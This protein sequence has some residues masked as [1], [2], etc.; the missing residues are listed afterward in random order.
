MTGVPIL[1]GVLCLVLVAA[2]ATPDPV[3]ERRPARLPRAE[4]TMPSA[5]GEPDPGDRVVA[6]VGEQKIRESDIGEFVIRYL[7]DRANEA[8]TH[9]IDATILE[10]EAREKGIAVPPDLL[11]AEV[12]RQLAERERAVTAQ[13]GADVTLEVYLRD[14]YG[15]TPVEHREDLSALVRT[16]MLRDR[17]IRFSRM[18]KERV[19]VRDAVFADGEV[20]ARAA[21][22]AREGADLRTLAGEL[23]R[24]SEV[25]PALARGDF[26]PAAL[27]A[28][29]FGLSQGEVSD[30]VAVDD[31]F[32]VLRLI[33]REPAR[34]GSWE[35]LSAE[36][37]AGIKSRPIE[38]WE[39]TLWAREMREKHRA[40]VLR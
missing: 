24:G 15:I 2:C 27:G 18:R 3:P 17:V 40:R 10:R 1:A 37:E 31:L 6:E 5:D 16:R 34:E 20:A 33:S 30:P 12:T 4:S 19:R 11:R 23:G 25:S 22:S 32:H 7:R 35:S 39:Y 8:L 14:R 36:V 28:A 38:Q 21:V 29:A 13:F 26:T 9:L